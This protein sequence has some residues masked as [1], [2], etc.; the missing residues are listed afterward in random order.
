MFYSFKGTA[1]RKS[2]FFAQFWGGLLLQYN[3]LSRILKIR[4]PGFPSGVQCVEKPT[5]IFETGDFKV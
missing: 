1:T 4:E 3:G 5:V 2:V